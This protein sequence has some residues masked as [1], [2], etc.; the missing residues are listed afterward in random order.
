MEGIQTINALKAV[1]SSL[2]AQ[3]TIPSGELVTLYAADG[4]PIAKIS[5]DDLVKAVASVMAS[6]SQNT[7]SKLLGVQANGTPMGI[8]AS[9]LASVLGAKLKIKHLD[10]EGTTRT[11]EG[12]SGDYFG[13]FI[14]RNS[15]HWS[16][17]AIF[18]APHNGGPTT[19]QSGN[20]QVTEES[21]GETLTI[22]SPGTDVTY[23]LYIGL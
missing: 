13:F 23:V 16:T 17:S 12:A 21:D 10:F 8:G 9:D 18:W 3:T 7:F 2:P 4:T 5:R 19:I 11:I 14:F 22:T 20:V 6:N 1:V 15:Q